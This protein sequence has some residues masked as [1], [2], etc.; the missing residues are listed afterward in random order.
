MLLELVFDQTL[1]GIFAIRVAG[2]VLDM[3]VTGSPAA[4]RLFHAMVFS[5]HPSV[6]DKRTTQLFDQT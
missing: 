4:E 5:L 6:R 1:G 2:K 3:L